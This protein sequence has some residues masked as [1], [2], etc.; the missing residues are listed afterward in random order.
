MP[1]GILVSLADVVASRE[2]AASQGIFD[3]S[4]H[5]DP[6]AQAA[7]VSCRGG[8][9]LPRSHLCSGK[10]SDHTEALSVLFVSCSS[11]AHLLRQS[12]NEEQKA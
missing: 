3:S 9:L 2:G 5:R 1:L 12:Q 7:G 6:E 11:L 4:D 8:C 10:G